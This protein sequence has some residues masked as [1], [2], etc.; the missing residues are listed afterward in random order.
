MAIVRLVEQVSL[1]HKTKSRV[2][3]TF[4][5]SVLSSLEPAQ[6]KELVFHFH[7]APGIIDISKDCTLGVLISKFGTTMKLVLKRMLEAYDVAALLVIVN[8]LTKKLI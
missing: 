5:V 8:F 2:N 6:I 7:V 4:P 1:Q 3:S